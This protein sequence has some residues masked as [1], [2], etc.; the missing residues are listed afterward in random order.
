MPDWVVLEGDR[1]VL[2]ECKVRHISRKAVVTGDPRELRKCLEDVKRGLRQLQEFRQAVELGR[3]GL[4]RL[5]HCTE[6]DPVLVTMEPLYLSNS[7]PF[8]QFMDEITGA[9]VNSMPRL[10]LSADELERLQPHFAAG[11]S[12]ADVIPDLT[13]R[14]FTEVL[15]GLH[16]RTGKSYGDTFLWQKE[17]KIYERLGVPDSPQ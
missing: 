7:V 17:K 16:D 8:R 4:E 14:P 1:A 15:R 5:H 12:F 6:I 9:T 3:P 13:R 11:I 10:M 2:I